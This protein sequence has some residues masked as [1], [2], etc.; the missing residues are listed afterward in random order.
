VDKTHTCTY[1]KGDGYV[2]GWLFFFFFFLLIH[3][4]LQGIQDKFRKM[5]HV[6]V[7]EMKVDSSGF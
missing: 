1:N 2:N 5:L 6:L 7:M 4:Y 3:T